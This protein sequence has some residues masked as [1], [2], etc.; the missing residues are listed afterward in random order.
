[1]KNQGGD[2]ATKSTAETTE[3]VKNREETKARRITAEEIESDDNEQ[4]LLLESDDETT[5]SK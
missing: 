1:M 5:G 3:G 2:R 4:M